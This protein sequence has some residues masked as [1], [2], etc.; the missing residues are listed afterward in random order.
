MVTSPFLT[1]SFAMTRWHTCVIFTIF[2]H[3]SEAVLFNNR[4]HSNVLTWIIHFRYIV[5]EAFCLCS[6]WPY[7]LVVRDLYL[8]EHHLFQLLVKKEHIDVE[9]I[10]L[11]WH[12]F[13]W[14]R[15]PSVMWKWAAT[16]ASLD[17]LCFLSA[18]IALPVCCT[19]INLSLLHMSIFI[20]N[21]I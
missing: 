8:I 7:G 17:F 4:K 16:S 13:I 14:N 11:L 5:I 10:C 15:K 2:S 3:Q 12:K 9:I 6:T 18:F 20:I 21:L 1:P 19:P